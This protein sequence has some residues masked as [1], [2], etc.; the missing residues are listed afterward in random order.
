MLG[1]RQHW[2]MDGLLYGVSYY[3]LRYFE[4]LMN[5]LIQT[6]FDGYGSVVWN[7]MM[8]LATIDWLILGKSIVF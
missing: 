1:I 2:L 6:F 8:N 3:Q 5:D 4:G 7:L